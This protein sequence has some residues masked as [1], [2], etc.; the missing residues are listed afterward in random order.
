MALQAD[1]HRSPSRKL[2]LH[3]PARG[4][5]ADAGPR[6]RDRRGFL[7]RACGDLLLLQP[8]DNPGRTQLQDGGAGFRALG[9]RRRDIHLQGGPRGQAEA[10]AYGQ[11]LRSGSLRHGPQLPDQ[12]KPRPDILL[13]GHH[14]TCICH[15]D[16]SQTAGFQEKR[17]EVQ[18]IC[19]RLGPASGPGS[20]RYSGECQPPHPDL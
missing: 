2:P 7:R 20:G 4:L 1:V 14:H 3:I 16:R 6:D 19:H 11:S 17:R 12:G 13:P 9:A 8:A 15:R 5:P 18:T 10:L